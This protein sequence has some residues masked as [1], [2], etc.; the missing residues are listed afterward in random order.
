M[1]VA[2]PVSS[3]VV[4]QVA[5]RGSV[6]VGQLEAL[7][8]QGRRRLARVGECPHCPPE[9]PSRTTR[10]RRGE[11]RTG[12]SPS[13][14]AGRVALV[15][16]ARG[17][18]RHGARRTGGSRSRGR[19]A[20]ASSDAQWRGAGGGARGAWAVSRARR[21]CAR[22]RRGGRARPAGMWAGVSERSGEEEEEEEGGADRRFRPGEEGRRTWDRLQEGLGRPASWSSMVAVLCRAEARCGRARGA[23]CGGRRGRD[24]PAAGDARARSLAPSTDDSRSSPARGT[25]GTDMDTQRQLLELEKHPPSEQLRHAHR[26]LH[27]DAHALPPRPRTARS[28]H[29]RPYRRTDTLGLRGRRRRG[30]GRA[31]EAGGQERLVGRD[32]PR[33]RRL[34]RVRRQR[35]GRARELNGRSGRGG[36]WC[37]RWGG[38][39]VVRGDDDE[40][41][42][43]C[44]GG[45]GGG[46]RY[47]CRRRVRAR[48]RR[49]C[50]RPRR[51]ANHGRRS[52]CVEHVGHHRARD[53]R[54]PA[55]RRQHGPDRARRRSRA[56]RAV[57]VELELEGLDAR[58][59]R[60]ELRLG[61]GVFLRAARGASG[62]RA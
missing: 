3:A 29:R 41:R 40:S 34:V 20:T 49:R 53:P 9:R 52:R 55:R 44:R 59:R 14:R 61:R 60:R 37:E 22:P 42:W 39:R 6:H 47:R 62:R 21:R 11:R 23:R 30:T 19:S 45:G 43:W 28:C 17:G 5:L 26:P 7:R 33:A 2:K 56:D 32:R 4:I 15:P 18:R 8:V 36:G 12:S 35:R 25:R 16:G 46:G 48:H 13:S 24:K 51:R 31:C 1:A 50:A 38:G 27:L 10:R 57:Q 54:A 58:R